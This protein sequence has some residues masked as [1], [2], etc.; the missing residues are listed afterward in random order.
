MEHAALS[1]SSAHKWLRC[2]PSARLEESLPDTK[3]EYAAE[4]LLAHALAELK[5]R[6]AFLRL[7]PKTYGE[8]M[9]A[10]CR[11]QYYDG[12]MQGYTDAYVNYVKKLAR[13][14]QCKPYVGVEKRL[15]YS[16]WA[17]EGFGTAD[18]VLLG[19]DTLHVVDFKYGRGVPVAA[20][21]NPQMKLYALGA[22]EAYKLLYPISAVKLT[23]VQPRLEVISEWAAPIETLLSWGET[24][25][26]PMARLA[27]EGRGD[28]APGSHCRFCRARPAC[29]A[30]ADFYQRLDEGSGRALPPLIT[31]EEAGAILTRAQGLTDWYESLKAHALSECLAG[32]SVPGWKAVEGRRVR[33]LADYAAAASLLAASGVDESSLYRRAPLPLGELEKLLTP[34]RFSELLGPCLSTQPGKP[35]L[36]EESDRR[37]VYHLD[38]PEIDFSNRK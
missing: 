23:V 28:Y 26:K 34:K 37:Q 20:E 6:K 25:V 12:E 9:D 15:D 21:N 29:R 11:G 3:S 19:G 31:N 17:P 35:A 18:C 4:G 33:T 7:R 32:R 2:P 13:T 10:L 1:A 30:R 36:V 16:A 22:Y 14:S 5:L 27:W 8:A 24:V 38:N